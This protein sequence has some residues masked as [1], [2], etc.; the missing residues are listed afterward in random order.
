MSD[1]PAVFLY[2][3]KYLVLY[4]NRF[5]DLQVNGHGHY[6]FETLKVAR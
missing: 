2:R 6:Q 5:A 4:S 1:V 3:Q